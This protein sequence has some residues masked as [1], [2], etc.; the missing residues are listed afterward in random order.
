MRS[1]MDRIRCIVIYIYMNEGFGGLHVLRSAKMRFGPANST[2]KG[3]RA[4]DLI[5]DNLK[6]P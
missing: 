5:F 2:T 3:N 1:K 4:C 6:V